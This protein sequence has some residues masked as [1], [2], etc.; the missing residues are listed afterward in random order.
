MLK[1]VHSDNSYCVI[2]A[3]KLKKVVVI[4]LDLEKYYY[5]L[6]NNVYS[7]IGSLAEDN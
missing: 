1:W 7:Y 2:T 5:K 6:R 3:Y 4:F